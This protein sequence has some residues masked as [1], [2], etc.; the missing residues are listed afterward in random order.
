M[1][2]QIQITASHEEVPCKEYTATVLLYSAVDLREM[3]RER[4]KNSDDD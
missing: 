2:I 4:T 1:P 3:S